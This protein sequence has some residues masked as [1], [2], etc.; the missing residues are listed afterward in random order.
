MPE[1]PEVQTVVNDLNRKVLGRKLVR[2]WFDWPRSIKG[3]TPNRF[4]REVRNL[5]IESITRRAKNIVF[6]LKN[7]FLKEYL[8]L[9]HLKMTGHILMGGPAGIKNKHVHFTFFLSGNATMNLSDVRKFAKVVFGPRDKIE[10]SEHLA[11]LGPEPLDPAFKLTDFE[12]LL[13][14]QKRKIKQVLMDPKII[15]GI[16]NIYSDEVLWLSKTSPL[17]PANS[18][19][20]HEASALY[21]AIKKILKGAIRLR[22]SSTSDFRDTSGL[23]GRYGAKH[24]VY[25][26]L[27]EPCPRCGKDI[28]RVRIGGR[29]AHYCAHCQR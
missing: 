15:A 14:K 13:K 29:S 21:K 19:N 28:K 24:Q 22:G 9:I 6:L 3:T 25:R 26:R 7:R 23:S 5:K 27:G 11:H 16:G 12:S 18:I 8:L 10:K 1:L 17:R 20:K 2:V 4:R